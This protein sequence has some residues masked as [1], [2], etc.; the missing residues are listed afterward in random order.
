ML[1]LPLSSSA[2]LLAL[3]SYS[4][5]PFVTAVAGAVPPVCCITS[6][7]GSAVS[8]SKSAACIAR[9]VE[10]SHT[11]VEIWR[12]LEWIGARTIHS[13]LV[14]TRVV[15]GAFSSCLS[16]VSLCARKKL[17]CNGMHRR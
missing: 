10:G 15:L 8:I 16:S 11:T 4:V 6:S 9:N 2:N 1:P 5:F 7:V 3:L 13:P 17:E 12:L 14:C